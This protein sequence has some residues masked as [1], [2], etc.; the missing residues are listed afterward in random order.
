MQLL[1]ERRMF[2]HHI[3]HLV[4]HQRR[5][6]SFAMMNLTVCPNIGAVVE[7]CELQAKTCLKHNV[8]VANLE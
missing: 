5:E 2:F 1:S 6:Y 4:V 7:I 8:A 3:Q